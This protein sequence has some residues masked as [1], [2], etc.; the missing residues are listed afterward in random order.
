M[1]GNIWVDAWLLLAI[2]QFLL[3]VYQYYRK[4]AGIVD[5]GWALSMSFMALWLAWYGKGNE[6]RRLLLAIAGSIWGLRLGLHLFVNRV[7]PTAE[8]GRY[9]MLRESWGEAANRNF[10]IFFQIQAAWSLLFALP[11]YAVSQNAAA[12]DRITDL[13]A[14]SIWILALTGETVADLQLEKWKKSSENRGK[15]CRSGFW[16]Y[17]R[18]PNYFFEWLHWWSYVFL[19]WSSPSFYLT[20]AGPVIMLLFL[21]KLTGIP[22]TE[23]RALASRGDDYRNYQQTTSAFFPWWPKTISGA[24]K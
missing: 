6:S 15:T 18:H 2:W 12:L 4:D 8:D 13:I 1:S 16:R 10:F 23:K 7:M 22:Y 3:F 21:Y 17:S 11:F 24:D 5:V 20:F 9:A 19:A 14:I